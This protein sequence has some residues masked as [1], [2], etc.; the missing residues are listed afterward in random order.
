MPEMFRVG[1]IYFALAKNP[2]AIARLESKN[3]RMLRPKEF[4]CR[5]SQLFPAAR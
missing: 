5:P 3:T 4:L 1:R 2:K